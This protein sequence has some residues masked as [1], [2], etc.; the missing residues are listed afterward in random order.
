MSFFQRL[1]ALLRRAVR[2]SSA[3]L[4]NRATRDPQ[5]PSR[6]WSSSARRRAAPRRMRLRKASGGWRPPRAQ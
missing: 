6:A 5:T 3:Q 2:I 4:S 1:R